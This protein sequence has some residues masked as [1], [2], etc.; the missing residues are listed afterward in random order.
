VDAGEFSCFLHDDPGSS[1]GDRKNSRLWLEDILFDVSPQTLYHLSRDENDL[2]VPAALWTLDGQLLVA[3]IFR[4]E[5]QD[6]ADSH[7]ASCHQFQE[8]PVSHLRR[9]EDD[10]IDCFFLNNVPVDGFAWPVDFPQHRGIA[11]VLS[12][13]IEIGLDEIEEGLEV[14]V[15]AVLGLLLSALGDFVQ[16]GE[17]LLGCNGCKIVVC[18]KVLTELGE[19]GT[20]RLDR[21]FF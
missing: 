17:D 9:P 12:G 4:G 15:A 13:W 19:G 14:G 8:E 20:V 1:I 16:E 21:I 10:L 18:A 11:R 5:L 7:A 3:D 2:C 6:F